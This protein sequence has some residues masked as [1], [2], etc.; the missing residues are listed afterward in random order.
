MTVI[1][2]TIDRLHRYAGSEDVIEVNGTLWFTPCGDI[3]ENHTIP[4]V[5]GLEE[6]G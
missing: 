6:K 1:T 5:P 2:Q 3:V 4:I